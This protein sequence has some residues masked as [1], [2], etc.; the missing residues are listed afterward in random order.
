[1]L[2][3]VSHKLPALLEAYQ[4]T[5]KAARVGFDW[6]DAAQVFEK[7]DEESGEL[8]EEIERSERNEQALAE[9]LGDLIFVVT[10]LARKLNVEP[11]MALKAANRK[12]RRR[13]GFIE[14]QLTA[15]GRSCGEATLEEMDALWNEAKRAEKQK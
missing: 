2:D 6:K 1:L 9:E 14:T 4:L 12:F 13:F 8:R 5:T 10:N 7:L 11:E 3:G 15:Q